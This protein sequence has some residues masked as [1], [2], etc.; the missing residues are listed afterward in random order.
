MSTLNA[1]I[2]LAKALLALA[3]IVPEL[4]AYLRG[5]GPPPADITT[6]PRVSRARQA[7]TLKRAKAQ[8]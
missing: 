2:S 8:P 3:P 5:D 1:F 6:L 7:L 4:A